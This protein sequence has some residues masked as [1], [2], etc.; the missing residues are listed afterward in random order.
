MVNVVTDGP[1]L[2]F[3]MFKMLRNAENT[4]AFDDLVYVICKHYFLEII[5]RN[6]CFHRFVFIKLYGIKPFKITSQDFLSWI[7]FIRNTFKN[8]WHHCKL[9]NCY[10][11]IMAVRGNVSIRNQL[12]NSSKHLWFGWKSFQSSQN[13]F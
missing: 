7:T 3:H 4:T 6:H 1:M 9:H 12:C 8:N 10:D 2:V 13:R 5:L 11:T